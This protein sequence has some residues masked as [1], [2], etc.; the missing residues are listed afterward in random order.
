MLDD[1]LPL[2]ISIAEIWMFNIYYVINTQGRYSQKV[3]PEYIDFIQCQ[4][5][6]IP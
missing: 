5:I 6:W 3:N 4:I 2:N 1:V